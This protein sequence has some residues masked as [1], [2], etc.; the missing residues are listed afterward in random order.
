MFSPTIK[1]LGQNQDHHETKI[2]MIFHPV[3]EDPGSVGMH[4]HSWW[5]SNME[6]VL[7]IVFSQGAVYYPRIR[8]QWSWC[9]PNRGSGERGHK[10]LLVLNLRDLRAVVPRPARYYGPSSIATKPICSTEMKA[11]SVRELHV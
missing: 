5:C 2:I 3:L 6:R 11:N 10:R 8:G 4:L 1:A 9:T 7:S